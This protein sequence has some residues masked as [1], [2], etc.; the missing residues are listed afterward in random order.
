VQM[1]STLIR[2]PRGSYQASL[3]NLSAA[4]NKKSI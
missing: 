4:D 2:N 1:S 3:L